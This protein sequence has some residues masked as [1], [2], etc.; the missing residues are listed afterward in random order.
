[1]GASG[2]GGGG[3][4]G[5]GGGGGIGGGEGALWHG[6]VLLACAPLLLFASVCIEPPPAQQSRPKRTAHEEDARERALA[7][8]VAA[9]VHEWSRPLSLVLAF[10]HRIR[11][12]LEALAS[13]PRPHPEAG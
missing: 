2:G 5:G 9:A 10:L 6:E 4:G 7:G 13:H 8:S 1:M 12:S 3:I 11:P